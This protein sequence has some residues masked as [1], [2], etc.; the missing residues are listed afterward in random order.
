MKK[1]WCFLDLGKIS[2]TCLTKSS[3]HVVLTVKLD[4]KWISVDKAQAAVKIYK[5][6]FLILNNMPPNLYQANLS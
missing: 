4:G 6:H 2:Y 3:Y 5:S 1:Y